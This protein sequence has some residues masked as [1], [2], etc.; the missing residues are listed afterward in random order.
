SST[1][2]VSASRRWWNVCAHGG[3]RST[4]KRRILSR[5]A[6]DQR[7]G[8][9]ALRARAGAGQRDGGAGQSTGDQNFYDL[10]IEFLGYLHP[11]EGVPYTKGELGRR[12]LEKF[13]FER[14]AGEL[15]YQESMFESLQRDLTRQRGRKLPP[16]PK[17]RKY[18]HQ[19]VPDHERLDR[20]LGG[21]LG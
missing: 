19:L 12:E 13:I 4:P 6:D 2:N 5:L 10:S 16:T 7:A 17:F 1:T 9:Q 21:L 8:G 14:H 3:Q 18:A 11:V 20:F 15:E